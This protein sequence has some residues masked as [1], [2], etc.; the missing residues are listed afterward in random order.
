MQEKLLK[1]NTEDTSKDDE[2]EQEEMDREL[3]EALN[4]E[5]IPK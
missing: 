2:R 3:V 4:A 1:N 5:N